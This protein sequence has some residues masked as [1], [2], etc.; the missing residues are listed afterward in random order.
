VNQLRAVYD[1]KGMTQLGS[2]LG[3]AGAL[4]GFAAQQAVWKTFVEP[5]RCNAGEY[6]YMAASKSGERFFL[7]EPV[8]QF[9][10]GTVPGV[11]SFYSMVA[12]AIPN[13]VPKTRP[14]LREI[15]GHVV[16]TIASDQFG[17]LRLPEPHGVVERP[18]LA[19]NRHWDWAQHMLRE[20]GNA[21]SEWPVVL[22]FVANRLITWARTHIAPP[23]GAR[24]VMESAIAMAK[25]DPATVPGATPPLV[26]QTWSNR[27]IKGNMQQLVDEVRLRMP[28]AIPR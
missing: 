14:D 22:G 6:F 8:N 10:L 24:L 13:P 17:V 3:A 15:I 21:P 23:L 9:L 28:R 5:Q 7:G 27:A 11:Y 4:G 20:A 19:L 1:E 18:R 2:L 16:R 12:G 26:P 25:V